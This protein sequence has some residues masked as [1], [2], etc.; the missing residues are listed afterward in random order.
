MDNRKA[1][2]V[3]IEMPGPGL[4]RARPSRPGSKTPNERGHSEGADKDTMHNT[5]SQ[6]QLYQETTGLKRRPSPGAFQLESERSRPTSDSDIR[7][8]SGPDARCDEERTVVQRAPE[9]KMIATCD[10]RECTGSHSPGQCP[11]SNKCRGCQSTRHSLANCTELGKDCGSR[12]SIPPQNVAGKA[13]ALDLALEKSSDDNT[14]DIQGQRPNLARPMPPDTQATTLASRRQQMEQE[15]QAHL[16]EMDKLREQ[17]ADWDVRW[18][19]L[20]EEERGLDEYNSKRKETIRKREEIEGQCREQLEA[21]DRQSEE[22]ER[23]HTH[24]LRA[25]RERQ[26]QE[27]AEL[28][29]R[30]KRRHESG[31]A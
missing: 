5:L 31:P 4:K 13:N 15:G 14:I 21:I 11:L 28:R 1:R 25:M 9:A 26:D 29:Q 30:Q 8:K 3:E 20:C 10:N 12:E 16:L 23:Q 19:Y 27:L 7:S 22:D 18:D 24:Q 2:P 6:D 17:T